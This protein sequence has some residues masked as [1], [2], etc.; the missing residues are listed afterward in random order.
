MNEIEIKSADL[1]VVTGLIQ[2]NNFEALYDQALQLKSYIESVEVT[3][4]TIKVTKKM[5]AAVN[6]KVKELEDKRIQVKK[7]ILSP[8]EQFEKQV[9][10]IVNVVKEADSEVRKKVKALEEQERDEKEMSITALFNKRKPLYPNLFMFCLEDFLT[11]K[12]L[13]KTTSLKSIEE[14]MVQWFETRKRDIEL[15]NTM[16][17]GIEI[18]TEYVNSLDL[19]AAMKIVNTRKEKQREIEAMKEQTV[20]EKEP[21]RFFRYTVFNK[22][23]AM[24]LESFMNEVQIEFK[25]DGN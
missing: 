8:Y 24:L 13:N 2:F 5:L 23:D 9:R 17:D 11:Q 1:K 20:P 21:V 14:E 25:K 7:E 6:G 19:A 3:E 12:H 15:I 16:E 18:M 22:K 4:E 10:Q